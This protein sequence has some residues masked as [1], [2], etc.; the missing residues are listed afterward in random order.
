MKVRYTSTA[1]LEVD[2]ILT[3]IADENPRAA[4][5]VSAELERTVERLCRYPL[6]STRKA[7]EENTRVARVGRYPYLIFYTV[8]GNEIVVLQVRHGARQ[9]P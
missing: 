1:L 7:D 4:A 9:R 8:E 5:R 6:S 3:Y 2:H